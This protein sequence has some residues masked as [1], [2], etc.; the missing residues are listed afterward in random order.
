ML[1][2]TL[3]GTIDILEQLV[4]KT[5]NLKNKTDQNSLLSTEYEDL[6]IKLN[7]LSAL[8]NNEEIQTPIDYTTLVVKG[9]NQFKNNYLINSYIL[10]VQNCTIDGD[11]ILIDSSTTGTKRVFKNTKCQL[12][13]Q[14]V[15]NHWCI[16]E[17]VYQ[18]NGLRLSFLN[19]GN[20]NDLTHESGCSKIW[21]E[22]NEHIISTGS[23]TFKNYKFP[24]TN[25]SYNISGKMYINNYSSE[26]LFEVESLINNK[27]VFSTS[28]GKY[29]LYSKSDGHWAIHQ[30][31]LYRDTFTSKEIANS[32]ENLIY[33]PDDDTVFGNIT[34]TLV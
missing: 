23:V 21:I 33:I 9:F 18:F 24:L 11:Y 7:S 13:I 3:S 5:I 1:D 15:N 17:P 6:N 12:Y 25:K 20:L 2:Q 28:D 27:S 19:D 10:D 32:P 4:N 8:I 22:P 26:N 34:I 31:G 16:Y 14:Y 29:F 30:P